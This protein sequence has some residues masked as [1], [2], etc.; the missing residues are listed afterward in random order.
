MNIVVAVE[1]VAIGKREALTVFGGDYDT[2]DGTCVRDYL[3]VVDCAL[4]EFF[5]FEKIFTF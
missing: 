4:G 2:P 1:Q 3:H 5:L